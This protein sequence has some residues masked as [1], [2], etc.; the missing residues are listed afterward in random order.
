M[1]ASAWTSRNPVL[2]SCELG[3]ESDTGRVK[4]G[5]GTESWAE[6]PYMDGSVS[7]ALSDKIEYDT[8]RLATQ[9]YTP[10]SLR[11]MSGIAVR[12]GNDVAKHY[13]RYADC[14]WD[15]W[16]VGGSGHWTGL[17]FNTE[18]A[19]Y[20]FLDTNCEHKPL[21]PLA[22]RYNIMGRVYD[23]VDPTVPVINKV[24]GMNTFL[25]ILKDSRA[26]KKSYPVSATASW[27]RFAQWFN[28]LAAQ[29]IGLPLGLVY[30]PG[31]ER[32]LWLPR[33]YRTVYHQPY[34]G[35]WMQPGNPSLPRSMYDWDTSSIVPWTGGVMNHETAPGVGQ[36]PIA[37]TFVQAEGG[38]IWTTSTT[39]AAAME[40]AG[41][42]EYSGLVL[43]RMKHATANQRSL[44]VKPLGIDRIGTN[45]FDETKYTLHALYE[46]EDRTAR[47]KQLD[48]SGTEASDLYWVY[49]N[50]W[51]PID[52]AMMARTGWRSMNKIPSVRFFLR[53]NV[54]GRI[55]APSS[56]KVKCFVGE[57]NAPMK[58]LVEGSEQ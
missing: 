35:F 31:A 13:D 27:P 46:M 16:E 25:S 33:T 14:L 42:P 52:G 12:Q 7:S 18:A 3:F 40:S 30:S 43:Y 11:S 6:L 41:F 45:W 57:H 24:W 50:R 32:L 29:N 2:A 20:Q 44:F 47:I 5:N 49:K 48:G 56:M 26:Y 22:Y 9:T 21:D 54:T 36:N 19:L 1:M 51:S 28:S 55:S 39:P 17:Q 38:T 53:S 8:F 15:I 58:W 34:T 4:I 23:L 37:W 10:T